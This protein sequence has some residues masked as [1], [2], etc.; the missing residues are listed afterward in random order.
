MSPNGFGPFFS[1]L[2]FMSKVSRERL[3]ARTPSP[4]L[5]TPVDSS[6]TEEEEKRPWQKPHVFRKAQNAMPGTF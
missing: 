2:S 6:G 1:L 4:L 5:L 3:V